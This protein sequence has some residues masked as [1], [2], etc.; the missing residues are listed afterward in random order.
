MYT[1]SQKIGDPCSLKDFIN[2]YYLRIIWWIKANFMFDFLTDGGAVHSI[3]VS[4]VQ[5][6]GFKLELELQHVHMG[7]LQVPLTVQKYA[8]RWTA[9][10]NCP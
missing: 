8:G 1:T 6:P 3:S 7:F 10:L 4:H 2:F 5:G 9:T